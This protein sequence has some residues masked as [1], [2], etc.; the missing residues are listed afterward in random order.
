MLFLYNT[1]CRFVSLNY[2]FYIMENPKVIIAT[3]RQTLIEVLNEILIKKSEEKA[4][5]EFEKDKI[6]KLQ[7]AKLAGITIPTLNKLTKKGKFH[8]Y[9]LGRRK[10][11]LK[12]EL[13]DALRNH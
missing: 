2:K 9:N 5:P 8:Q 10:Y 11:F 12:S 4:F 13:V 7:A 1:C 6:S 3:D